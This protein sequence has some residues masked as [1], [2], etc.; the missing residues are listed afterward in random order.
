MLAAQQYG[1]LISWG[2]QHVT[3]RDHEVTSLRSFFFMQ[4]EITTKK[5]KKI[6]LEN[7]FD[8]FCGYEQTKLKGCWT[9]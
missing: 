6:T 7:S 1:K 3:H 4:I 2:S 9:L 5:L 8:A